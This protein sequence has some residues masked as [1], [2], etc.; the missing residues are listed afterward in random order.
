[1]FG[2]AENLDN[3]ELDPLSEDVRNF[4]KI[5]AGV[6]R[7]VQVREHV[8]FGI[9]GIYSRAFVPGALSALYD[10]DQNGAMAFM[11]LKVQ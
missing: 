3:S 1:L 7:D 9:G 2:R 8:T 6:I 4:S 10:G 11:R 5:S